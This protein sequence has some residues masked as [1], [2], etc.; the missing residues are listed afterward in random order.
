MAIYLRDTKTL[1][2]EGGKSAVNQHKEFCFL[3][4]GAPLHILYIFPE[5]ETYSTERPL[6]TDIKCM[7]IIKIK[8][9]FL[10]SMDGPDMELWSHY[11]IIWLI[12]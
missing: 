2:N 9:H 8:L 7:Y 4:K 5:T 3:G 12:S 1:L 10:R 6:V 11:D